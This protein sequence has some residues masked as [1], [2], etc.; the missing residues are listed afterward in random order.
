MQNVEVS[1]FELLV[2]CLEAV[3]VL[4]ERSQAGQS[5][6]DSARPGVGGP[7]RLGPPGAADVRLGSAG[8]GRGL[9]RPDKR[10][11]APASRGLGRNLQ[12]W[13][14]SGKHSGGRAWG[15]KPRYKQDIAGLLPE[16]GK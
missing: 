7:A 3:G 5:G 4:A 11:A 8:A 12:G 9:R 1:R 13:E 14:P 16:R 2:G 15:W 6:R 10:G